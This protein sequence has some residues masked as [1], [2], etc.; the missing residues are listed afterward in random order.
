MTLKTA[1]RYADHIGLTVPDLDQAVS[2]FV[3]VFGA[4]EQARFA[5]HDNP[6]VMEHGIGVDPQA[7]LGAVLL[8]LT[9][10]LSVELFQ[11]QAPG[12]DTRMPE[13]SDIGGHHL[14][15]VVDD[16][17]TAIAE[18]RRR[19]DVRAGQPG[20][21]SYGP[22]AGGR[23]LY[24]RTSWGLVIE[25]IA[26]PAGEH[27]D[28]RCTRQTAASALCD[29]SRGGTDE[30]RPDDAGGVPAA[31]TGQPLGGARGRR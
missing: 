7:S 1:I 24:F 21:V 29:R 18:L 17:D 2:F 15:V 23:W 4:T 25:L 20:T 6:E 10:G 12:Q 19:P 26:D 9:P 14:C 5:V 13:V 3:E 22:H 28:E 8:Q 30:I 16:M 31:R 27:R 11:Y